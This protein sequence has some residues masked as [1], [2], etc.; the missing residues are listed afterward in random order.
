[1]GQRRRYS[2]IDTKECLRILGGATLEE[3]RANYPAMINERLSKDAMA[4]ET[5]WT[6]SIAVGSRA[7]VEAMAER[8]LHGQRLSDLIANYTELPNA[9]ETRPIS[10][11]SCCKAA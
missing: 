9:T 11:I 4:R 8:I 3:F 6:E 5:Q 10:P 2:V 7:F 1:M